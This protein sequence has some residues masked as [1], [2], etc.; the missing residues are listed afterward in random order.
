MT[1]KYYASDGGHPGSQDQGLKV[2]V[3]SFMSFEKAWF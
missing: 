2:N 1:V 3:M